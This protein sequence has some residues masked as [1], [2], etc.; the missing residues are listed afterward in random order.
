VRAGL[1]LQQQ[2]IPVFYYSSEI[3]VFPTHAQ[4]GSALQE[5]GNKTPHTLAG[6]D[7]YLEVEHASFL[8]TVG[9]SKQE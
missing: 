7:V 5:R 1:T 3:K 9:W 4:H 8:L 6:K 2:R